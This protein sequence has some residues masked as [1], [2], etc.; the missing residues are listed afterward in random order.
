[1]EQTPAIPPRTW[2]F[3]H[4]TWQPGDI[5]RLMGIV[6]VTPDSFSDGGQWVSTMAAVEHALA[7]AEQ[8]AD[9]LDIGGES[10]RPGAEPVSG[11][12]ELQRVIPVIE[13]LV[14]QT[15][16]PLSIDTTK[17]EVAAQALAA[18]ASI[19][20]DI[21]AATAD[22]RMPEVCA[23]SN[24]GIILMHMQGTPQTMQIDPRYQDVVQEVSDYLEARRR[25]FHALGVADERLLLDPG[26][27]FGKTARHNLQLLRNIPRL[28]ASGRPVLIGHSRKGFLKK[29]VGRNIDERL[30]GT[31]GVSIALAEQQVD[32]LRVH[33][34]SAVRDA[35]RAWQ[36][37]RSDAMP[38][39]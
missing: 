28:Q 30:A 16:V 1:M 14:R 8:G 39:E 32:M 13:Q 27:G 15:D 25:A 33:D 20:N 22:P 10:T 3:R 17:A 23:S 26:I 24:C 21:S 36:Q 19:V 11:A 12:V 29:L 18:G 2:V 4:T 37:I 6:N 5:P 34:I 9:V 31:I 38:P 35:L 7:L